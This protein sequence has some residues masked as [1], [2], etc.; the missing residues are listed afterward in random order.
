VNPPDPD[1]NP[2]FHGSLFSLLGILLNLLQFLSRLL[3]II[4][5][6]ISPPCF[7]PTS[8]LVPDILLSVWLS[9]TPRYLFHTFS[10]LGFF[11]STQFLFTPPLSSFVTLWSPVSLFLGLPL[12]LALPRSSALSSSLLTLNVQLSL[13]TPTTRPFSF[14]ACV[15]FL[16]DLLFTSQCFEQVEFVKKLKFMVESRSGESE[17]KLTPFFLSSFHNLHVSPCACDVSSSSLHRHHRNPAISLKRF[18][19]TFTFHPP[20]CALR[21]FVL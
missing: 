17:V 8:L 4:V 18:S 5:A 15:G 6:T 2:A 11:H 3:G 9:E 14:L 13:C 19:L 7:P 12:C 16:K 21:A 10:H 1:F 20:T